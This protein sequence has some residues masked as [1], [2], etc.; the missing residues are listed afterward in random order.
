[1]R[2]NLATVLSTV[3]HIGPAS[4]LAAAVALSLALALTGDP[5]INVPASASTE[6]H[7]YLPLI[8]NQYCKLTLTDP[9]YVA[10]GWDKRIVNAPDAWCAQTG[11]NGVTVAI[12]DSGADLTHPDLVANLVPGWD[13]VDGD[14]TPLDGN[15]HGTHVTGIIGAPINGIGVIGMAPG[16]KLMPVRVLNNAGTGST[17]TVAAAIKFAAD[18]SRIINLSLGGPD[19]TQVLRD[20][21]R[22]RG[23]YQRR[24]GGRLSRQLRRPHL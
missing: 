3:K 22:L 2:K 17:L 16:V 12:L 7:L 10:N 18:R 5:A 24:A 13:F 9:G 21:N 19:D 6:T 14:S 20:R 1:M 15:H 11:A 4:C 8:M 23:R